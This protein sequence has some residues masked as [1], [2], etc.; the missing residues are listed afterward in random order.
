MELYT[1]GTNNGE[2]SNLF[3]D[4]INTRNVAQDYR[5]S[6]TEKSLRGKSLYSL[7][8]INNTIIYSKI[9]LVIDTIR[10]KAL[11][12][13]AFSLALEK[14]EFLAKEAIVELLDE[15]HKRF[16]DEYMFEHKMNKG[17]ENKQ[18]V[19][20]YKTI[21]DIVNKYKVVH[22]KSNISITNKEAN[23]EKAALVYYKNKEELYQYLSNPNL[24]AY[25]D[26]PE[27]MFV[28]AALK[29]N[30]NPA[31]AIKN[32]GKDIT[33]KIDLDNKPY[34]LT[35][36]PTGKNVEIRV[37]GNKI[38][39]QT[40]IY[41]KD[42][43]Q[44]KSTYHPDCYVPIDKSGTLENKNLDEYIK[45][46]GDD[47]FQINYNK[48]DNPTPKTK[49]ISFKFIDYKGNILKDVKLNVFPKLQPTIEK[50]IFSIIFTGEELKGRYE[51]SGSL[52]GYN[53]VNKHILP[54][55]ISDKSEVKI[56]LSK[57]KNIPIK[58]ISPIKD[59]K[60]SINGLPPK[61][62]LQIELKDKDFDKKPKIVVSK[63]GYKE[64]EITITEEMVSKGEVEVSLEKKIAPKKKKSFLPL[65]KN[66]TISIL[67]ILLT[68]I[69]LANWG[70]KND[71]KENYCSIS[72]Y[73][74][75]LSY[76]NSLEKKYADNS[77]GVKETVDSTFVNDS[78]T[79]KDISIIK[80]SSIINFIIGKYTDKAEIVEISLWK[81]WTWLHKWYN[82]NAEQ[83]KYIKDRSE[84]LIEKISSKNKTQS[85]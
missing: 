4:K 27:I 85:K 79:V 49:T 82:I 39:D 9:I 74:K 31:L 69:T 59:F 62:D 13:L 45:I 10:S 17:D 16:E 8:T 29:G 60:I 51:I 83:K 30:E 46:E 34:Y 41:F 57:F 73:K 71:Y 58:V 3:S 66:I 22:R 42:K 37:N 63:D 84:K 43:I 28:D 36:Y 33:S 52:G 24:Q 64:T 7:R 35:H 6:S 81:P 23:P 19:Y 47:E 50:G 2:Q 25:T 1:Y 76:V 77:K 54:L 5:N 44:I 53:D 18:I 15:V 38:T 65:L 20:N 48:F 32:S 11:G 14:D 55:D 61:E 12:F 78:S 26:H 21:E 70:Y 56:E 80:D 72:E 40:S 67:L 68:L 75:D